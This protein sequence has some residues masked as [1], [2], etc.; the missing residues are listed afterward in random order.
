MNINKNIFLFKVAHV[1]FLELFF[2]NRTLNYIEGKFRFDEMG[3]DL[4]FNGTQQKEYLFDR[5]VSN[6]ALLLAL[7]GIMHIYNS[8]LMIRE[9]IL[10]LINPKSVKFIIK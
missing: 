10:G 2:L 4:E 9:I 3:I 7:V 1:N 6:F 8:L 5:K